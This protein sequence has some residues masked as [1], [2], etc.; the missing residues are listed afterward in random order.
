[1]NQPPARRIRA[2]DQERDEALR[3][4]EDA[5]TAGRLE[6]HELRERQEKALQ[7]RFTDEIAELV[8]D[9]PEGQALKPAAASPAP[10]RRH[11]GE[12][13]PEDMG[14]SVTIMSGKTVRIP[15]GTRRMSNFAYWGG[16][17]IYLTDAMGP[18]V[19]MTLNLPA[20]MA[21]HDIYVPKGVRIVDQSI[22]IMA[23]N[24]I[25]SNA[26]GDGSNG[27]LVIKGF[28][29]WAGHDVQLDKD[30]AQS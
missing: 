7:V 18:G 27:T 25:A 24:D 23:G 15:F 16:D 4:L 2:G 30:E 13:A 10:V 21:G 1:M 14:S 6:D 8:D 22:A 26:Q 19:V 20:I 17:D 12:L 29:F 5:F 3:I 11:S 9:L 28:L